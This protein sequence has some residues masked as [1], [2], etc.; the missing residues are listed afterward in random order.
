MVRIREEGICVNASRPKPG[1]PSTSLNI[2]VPD[3]DGGRVGI[4]F[5]RRIS[6]QDGVED[7]RGG[8]L[9]VYPPAASL[10]L[11]HGERIVGD[12]RGGLHTIYPAA[13]TGLVV[14]EGVVDDR[15]G[16]HL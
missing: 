4:E 16:E 2:A 5:V 11:V 7:R 12:H 3:A 15:R 6:P 10:D 13:E 1:L 14:G 9:A 8:L